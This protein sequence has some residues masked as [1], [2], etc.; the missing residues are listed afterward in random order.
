MLRRPTLGT[1]VRLGDLY[2]ARRGTFDPLS[3]FNNEAPGEAITTTAIPGRDIKYVQTDTYK[4]TF[5]H[6]DIDPGLGASFLA[7]IASVGGPGDYLHSRRGTNLEVQ[8]SLIFNVST[9]NQADAVSG[10]LS[11]R[12]FGTTITTHIVAEIA[13][14]S[15]NIVTVTK[16]L[17]P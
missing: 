1:T 15:S 10:Y 12:A 8:G 13:W 14:G 5:Q 11:R 16:R 17:T 6:L 2:D 3:L 7:R 9:V 4:A